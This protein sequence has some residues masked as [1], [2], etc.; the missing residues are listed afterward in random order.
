MGRKKWDVV[1]YDKEK[2]GAL[3]ERTGRDPFAVLLAL[4][5]GC[6][7]PEKL[8][9]FFRARE[10][11][12]SSPFLIKDMEKGAARIRQAVDAGERILVYGDY[13]ADGVTATA[14]LYTYLQSTGADVDFYIP[15]R[16]EDGYGLSARTAERVLQGGFDLVITVD[17]G[18]ASVEEALFFRENGIDLVVTDH[19][20]AGD[21]L[22]DCVAV[23]D[24]HRPDDTSPCKELAGVG[25]AFKLVCALEDGDPA[26]LTEE[27]LDIVALGTVADIVPLTGENRTL[28]ALGLHAL[29]NTS[30]PGLV[31]LCKCVGLSDK[32]VNS[33]TV[34]FSLAPKIN[35]A[36]RMGSA[37]TALELL[38]TDDPDRAAAL[39]R[40]LVDAN[41][42]RQSAEN[43]ILEEVTAM[44]EA[45]PAYETEPVL[46]VAGRGWHPGVIG[47]VASRMVETFGK[48]AFVI[49]V[50]EEGPAKGSCRS[51][52][53]FSLYEA[54]QK[55]APL[56]VKYGGHTLAAGFSVEE[57]DI[58]AFR[59]AINACAAGCGEISPTL[60]VDCR[61]NPAKLDFTV[62]NS[63]TLLE[64]FGASNPAPVFGLFGMTVIS[65]RPIGGGKHLRLTVSG[66]GA[67]VNVVCFGRTQQNFAYEQGDAVDLA[68][69][70]EK[71]E[72]LGVP[73]MS[74]QLRDIR[75]AGTDDGRLFR[76]LDA[77][78]RLRRGE[79]LP[80][81]QRAALLPDRSY[82]E[83]V[84]RYLKNNPGRTL[85]EEE[86]T[87]RIGRPYTDTGRTCAAVAALTELGLAGRRGGALQILPGAKKADLA[88]SSVLRMLGFR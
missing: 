14:L 60:R 13:D 76:I 58:P 17:N 69:R 68:V 12:L 39:A 27:F 67:T 23:I 65:V 26:M 25:V 1:S 54:L 32:N 74:L 24:P 47:I 45:D 53:G 43:E 82:M 10:N 49:S 72:Y 40:E 18:I 3:A 70:L 2:A 28:V 5:R 51:V 57:R 22:P 83:T 88:G 71:K 30:R 37:E 33:S 87:F 79:D 34:A 31:E 38:I 21:T 44:I 15:S 52:N 46:V 8:E 16:A 59:K 9:A 19:H 7:T 61:L 77:F 6:D 42:A 62:L 64:P 66:G 81:A 48:P 80:P 35:A 41:G 73:E 29:K 63:L 86:L 56:L 78:A 84:Y 75:P 11:P 36:G 50:A 4:S 55:C 20:Q 85:T